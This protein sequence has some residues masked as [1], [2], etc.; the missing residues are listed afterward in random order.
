[1]TMHALLVYESYFGNTMAVAGAVAEGL[2]S[3]FEVT[4]TEVAAAPSA[5]HPDVALLVVGGPTHMFGL[6]RVSSRKTATE[7][8]GA[9]VVSRGIGL[10][11]WLDA[12]G[13]A[14]GG[15]VPVAAFD[16]RLRSAWM[17]ARA[18][19]GA[20]KR[21][22]RKGFDALAGPEG[23]LVAGTPGPL[24]DGELERARR[25]GADLATRSAVGSGRR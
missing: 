3:R 14:P 25:W 7:Q 5:V 21:L 9:A 12:L 11:E 24:L 23:F 17:P 10:R 16:T 6:S 2:R 20:L 18:A 8:A 22:E 15:G 4:L 1:M 13:P 19:S